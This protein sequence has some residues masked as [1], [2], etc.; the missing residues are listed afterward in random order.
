MKFAE[1]V[2]SI[3]T[4]HA[5]KRIASAYVVDYVHL[6]TEQLRAN[7]MRVKNQFT[8]PDQVKQALDSASYENDDLTKRVLSPLIVRDILLNEYE[9]IM[10]MGEL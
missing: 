10:P 6:D 2:D 1:A 8:H 4:L 7:I 3:P 9:H 5:L